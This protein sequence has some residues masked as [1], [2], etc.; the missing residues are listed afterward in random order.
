[1]SEQKIFTPV[2]GLEENIMK[3]PFRDGF[4]YFAVDTGKIYMDY[5]AANGEE[6]AR[7]PFGGS[8][9]GGG[10]SGIFYANRPVSEDEK[11]EPI[12]DFDFSTIEGKE[13]PNVDDLI[14]NSADGCFYRVLSIN[15]IASSVTASRLT[16]AGGGGGSGGGLA[17]D[18]NLMVEDVP[19]VLIN[20]Q[21]QLL[22]F[23]ATSALNP[24]GQ[25]YDKTVKVS[26]RLEYTDDGVNYNTYKT[27]LITVNSGERSSIDIGSYAK[28]S[29]SSRVVLE[30]SQNNHP[31]SIMREVKFS[32]SDLTLNLPASFSNATYF[33]F[34]KVKLQVN[35]KGEMDKI[36]E[37]Y[38]DDNL[39]K[40][41]NLTAKDGMTRTVNITPKDATNGY[42]AVEIRLYQSINGKKGTMVEPIRFEIGVWDG[43]TNKPIIW[44]DTAKIKDTY[45]N[46]DTIQ[47]PFR[48]F[49][50][51]NKESTLVYFKR[52][53]INMDNSPQRVDDM[54]KFSI[55]EI[56][57]AE[58]GV[59][60][61]YTISCGE[62]DNETIR[63][64]EI[65]VEEDP[66]RK[67]FGIQKKQFLDYMLDTVG[68]GRSN[69]ESAAHRETLVYNGIAA[70]FN[71][72]NWYNNGW[73]RDE[74]NK[75]CLRV[76]N[77]AS[78]SIPVGKK[79]FAG[80]TN[81]SRSIEVCFKIRNVQDYSALIRNITRYKNDAE[82][83]KK[84]YDVNTATY[85][86]SYT[87]YD[88]FL[89]WYLKNYEH[90][91][92]D[93][94]TG[95]KRQMTYDDLEFDYID[96]LI[97]LSNV[98]CGYFSGN[99]KSA[100]G[101]CLG[102]QDAFFSNGTN[103][104]SV[105]YVEDR[106]ITLSAIY[107]NSNKLIYIYL[108]GLLTGVIKS[109]VDGFLV[110]TE[111]LVF[112]SK[113]CD[114][115]IYKL[116]FFSTDLN[117]NDVV[118]NYAADFEDVGI[119]DQNKLA[120][121]NRAINE[122]QLKFEN[123][124]QYNLDH[125]QAPLMPYIIFDT[126]NSNNGDKLSY[127]KSVNVVVG[128]E[129]VNAP[130]ELA[131]QNGEL[132]ELAK[133]DGLWKDGDT[134]E[135]KA[136]AVKK[137][138]RHHSPS[139][140]GENINMAVQGTSSE[141]YP[142]RNYKLKTKTAYDDDGEERIH[143]FLNRGPYTEE[144]NADKDGTSQSK[145][146]L[147]KGSYDALLTYYLDKEGTQVVEISETNPYAP[148][149]YYIENSRYVEIGKEK[150]RQK[151]FYMDNYTVGT[152][153]FTMKIDFMESSGSYNMGFTN[154]VHHGYSKHPLDDYKKKGALVYEND[155][156]EILPV[157]DKEF[158]TEELRTCVQGMRVMAFHKKS[159]GSYQY[160]GMYN[161]LLDKGSD[162]VFGFKPD[163]IEKANVSP[164]L[165]YAKNKKV[166]K[167]AECWEAENNIRTFCSFRDPMKRKDLS[168][169]VF[170]QND[171]GT[172]K[173]DPEGNPI[174]VLNSVKSGPVVLDSFEY[175]YNA[176]GDILDY[177]FDPI[178]EAD[179]Y[180]S[181]DVQDYMKENGVE[182]AFNKDNPS[183]NA[184]DRADFTLKKYKNLEKVCAWVWSTNTEA[185]LGQGSYEPVNVGL[186]P[187]T[188]NTYYIQDDNGEFVLDTGTECDNNIIYYT[189]TEE[190][191]Y[192]NA[193]VSTYLFKDEKYTYYT[194]I[195]NSYVA[196][197]DDATFDES[198]TYYILKN[199]TDEELST[200]EVDRLVKVC[201]DE[202]FDEAKTYYTYD[203]SQK[204]GQ[205]VKV[206]N[207]TSTDY[208]PGKYY[209][210]DEI[211]YGR[212]S[213]RYDT[214]EYRADKFTYELSKHF[215]IE[216][217]ATY[218][219]MT[220]VFE[221]YDSRGKNM[222]IASWGPQEAGGEYI[223]YPL[224]YDL[225]TQLG[226]N[227]TGIPS[228]EYNVDATEDGN[229]STSDSL[230]WNNFYKYFKTSAILA[231][232]KHLRGVDA[233]VSWPKLKY[234]PLQ[235]VDRIIKWYRTDP[236]E[237]KRIEHR[238]TR[239][240]VAVNLDE[241]YKYITITNPA[242][243]HDGSTGHI[244]SDTSGT[245]TYDKNGTYFYA[246]QGDR[247]LS[248]YQF[249]TN[250]LEYIDSWLNQGNYQRGGANRIRSRMAANN[251]S[252]TSDI[253]VEDK[254]NP[255]Y[256]EEG[257][258]VNPFD[259]EYWLTLTPTHSS[260]V[261]L[262]DDNEAYPSR[263]FDG[264]NSLKFDISAVEHG[265]RNSLN[266]PEQLLYVY[267]INQMKDLGDLSKLYLQEFEIS[268][269]AKQLTSLRLGYDGLEPV[270]DGAPAGGKRVTIDGK[271][272]YQWHNDNVNEPSI[273]AGKGADG[274]MP[275]LK[276]VNFCNIQV[277]RGTPTLDLESCEKLENFRAT[278]S[279]LTD[280]KFAE[281][282]SANTLYLPPSVTSLVLTEAR[283]LKNLITEYEYPVKDAEGKLIAKPGLY[284]Q[285]MFESGQTN[286]AKMNIFGGGLGYDSY[287]LLNKYYQ[288]REQQSNSSQIIMT[289]VAW[290]PYVKQIAGDVYI[291]GGKY[292][293]D[294]GHY[295]LVP[296][297]YNSSKW[298]TDIING[299]VYKLDESIP[300]EKI[301]QIKDI[302][303][304]ETFITNDKFIKNEVNK[305]PEITGIIYVDNDV[306]VDE[307][308]IRNEIQTRYPDLTF[309]FK[310]V[311]KAYTA[312]FLLMD[313]DEGND[314]TYQLVGSQTI[315]SGWFE[316]PITKYGD[317]SKLKPNHD[318]YGWAKTN[319]LDAEIIVSLDGTI[320]TWND[321]ELI[322]D[323]YDYIYYAICP[324][325]SWTVKF[326][327]EGSL[328]TTMKV[329]HGL[330]IEGPDVA[331]WKDDSV[332]DHDENYG[333]AYTWNLLG[334]S[335]NPNAVTPM[336][337][338]NYEITEDLELYA[339]WD[340]EP[341]SVYQNIHPEY[342]QEIGK[343]TY[344]EYGGDTKWNIEG[345]Q[346]GLKAK[347]KGKITVPAYFNGKPVV[348]LHPSFGAPFFDPDTPHDELDRNID[349][350]D[351]YY[352]KG[353]G[354]ELTHIFL[355][356]TP[357]DLTNVRVIPSVCFFQTLNLQYFEF[358]N[359]IREIQDYA[360]LFN[361]LNF[362]EH[363][364]S[365]TS[366]SIGGSIAKIGAGAFR[367]AFAPTVTS[368]EIGSNVTNIDKNGFGALG[369]HSN[370]T[371][372]S[373]GEMDK[374][375]QLVLSSNSNYQ[376]AFDFTDMGLPLANVQ[377]YTTNTEQ[378]SGS[379]L[380][381]DNFTGNMNVET[382]LV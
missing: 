355:E 304:L 205:A 8:A 152:T 240:L 19:A 338:K 67:D 155:A 164:L 324:I 63:K 150:T 140:V 258:K 212:R 369:G 57:N 308:R 33:D 97:N 32:T 100:V 231:K 247:S 107:N 81:A 75:T 191:T 110:D 363:L 151:F 172:L 256:D 236:T 89:A 382:P 351:S 141:F 119:Y 55:F 71:N 53:N 181:E 192:K 87:N 42:H 215:D 312:K 136:A 213:Y 169:D 357:N 285:G 343:A 356:K 52:N 371:N 291:E 379:K 348:K 9:G 105:S 218:F 83:Y 65:R 13:R 86:T 111:N 23:T 90:L 148:N 195:N 190:G 299:I 225:D 370:I 197:A 331:P 288:I 2:R 116:R 98:A 211:Q 144:Y 26:W 118:M 5:T 73:M 243:V 149:K 199:F 70:K 4:V 113:Y 103:T 35:V 69:A 24:K 253:W 171:D 124:Q 50:P 157:T 260:Y 276:E 184:Q 76:S 290:S 244:A 201:N 335:R 22:Y 219:I 80:D 36:V 132:D 316:N 93:P 202:A 49:D 161:M 139:W 64:V 292:F 339:V 122:Y 242:G 60:N 270:P 62:G 347:V 3:I 210:G 301:S 286:I 68:S 15:P 341:I 88:S 230:L 300:A 99:T 6:I 34:D 273:P 248:G 17:E 309:F 159:D 228:F 344:A 209:E 365:L 322:P 289:D 239:P 222:M 269:Q 358:A 226:I 130:L 216:Y 48:V 345:I 37:Y 296:Y 349:Y 193:Y 79:A 78:L 175:R 255:Y 272:Y 307:F 186:N 104:V 287:K 263:K 281:G 282:V 180:D 310:T 373:I 108:N 145:F 224:F 372:I 41:E 10:N 235:T 251:P 268:G 353:Y 374:P 133:K 237:T 327:S 330:T 120:E 233:G 366:S 305:M 254:N 207:I 262:G 137:Y 162:E 313:A 129:F 221:C 92:D 375:S 302:K 114:I 194:L 160:I 47:I 54:T 257:N 336:D 284:L 318:F 125:P 352:G 128:V 176:D 274:G 198:A 101:L 378:A 245:Y 25:P 154:L 311:N 117:V 303:M 232:Y 61:H 264:I 189:R 84:F 329:P 377:F 12:I 185:V 179:K 246:L 28:H 82:L 298:D 271:E 126:T 174:R 91:I 259:A 314:G 362:G 360:F 206:A 200:M 294:N 217:L 7:Q 94:K 121:E 227:N 323:V 354:G 51:L 127:A 223:W 332:L 102:P 367:R 21:P 275:L 280:V 297:V 16:V 123:V 112:N 177:I 138:Y 252:K 229:F 173:K 346:L 31:S 59:I 196:V 364:P 234:P 95:G 96:K 295:G 376:P 134:A 306:A 166:S 153:K 187:W 265:V 361:D 143:I 45:Y 106:I 250:R 38:F 158:K 279:N 381:L 319:K 18:I 317:I 109:T 320:N 380:V 115:D 168:F 30:A 278:G 208:A 85:L 46:Y 167:I 238:G 14:L 188:P 315:E 182:F 74:D 146:I 20:G 241:Y 342:F 142:R 43:V 44:L 29:A 40:V 267:G 337:L 325:H 334:Y 72:F 163:K 77:G 11:L 178:K 183:E 135:E 277:N 39:Y 131:Y 321:Q 266:Y 204:A 203:G 350:G 368:I 58:I 249:L 293:Q 359:G 56:A 283:M 66:N 333:P 165:K 156:G 214:K 326:Y 220:E 328:F 1:M 340:D 27:D 170:E 261:T 147:A